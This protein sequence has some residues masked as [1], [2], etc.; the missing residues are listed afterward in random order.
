MTKIEP[1]YAPEKTKCPVCNETGHM[2]YLSTLERHDY[3]PY[4]CNYCNNDFGHNDLPAR[5][6]ISE[7][8]L[9]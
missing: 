8:W 7:S 9:T 1:H 4:H 2:S 5:V 3:K 6:K